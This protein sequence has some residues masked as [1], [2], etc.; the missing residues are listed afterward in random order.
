MAHWQLKKVAAVTG[1]IS[2][3]MLVV[4]E[5]RPDKAV[6]VINVDSITEPGAKHISENFVDLGI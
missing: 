6:G 2:V 3:P 4:R 1:L 5:N